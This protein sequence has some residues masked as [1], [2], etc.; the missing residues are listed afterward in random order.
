MCRSEGIKDILQMWISFY[1]TLS[2]LGQS[3]IRTIM[4]IGWANCG[5]SPFLRE[6][7][8]NKNRDPHNDPPMGPS[9]VVSL[10]LELQEDE[11][12]VV[13]ANVLAKV[14][15]LSPC[16]SSSTVQVHQLPVSRSLAS[17]LP[18]LS[19]RQTAARCCLGFRRRRDHYGQIVR[20]KRTHP[21]Q[22]RLCR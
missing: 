5:I 21:D 6:R 13:F 11:A 19:T 7:K 4:L 20:D 14:F 12:A 18:F 15:P 8:Q 16:A 22:R 10:A 1:L 3:V 17:V 2:A 9:C